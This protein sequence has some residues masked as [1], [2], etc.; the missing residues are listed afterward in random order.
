LE[1]RLEITAEDRFVDPIEEGY[2]VVIRIN[3]A[4]MSRPNVMSERA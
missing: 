4:P 3:P 2:D 1:V